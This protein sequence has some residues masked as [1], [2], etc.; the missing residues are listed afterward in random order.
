[1]KKPNRDI[2][3]AMRKNPDN[4]K[5]IFYFNSKDPALIVPKLHPAM[6]WT[7]NFGS[8]YTY[9]FIAAV[10]LIIIAFSYIL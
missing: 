1:M 7:F 3:D 2:L 5:G 9:L 10:A 8:I 6:G 4:W